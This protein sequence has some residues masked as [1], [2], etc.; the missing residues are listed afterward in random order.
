MTATLS[1]W[2]IRST[3]RR[4][5]TVNRVADLHRQQWATHTREVRGEWWALGAEA[6]VRRVG[7][8]TITATPLHRDRR[9]PQDVA[10][11]APEV[12]AAIDGLIDA[13]LLVD[14][15]PTHLRAVMFMPPLVCGVDGLEL[16]VTEVA[17]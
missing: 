17:T 15:D 13:G 9:S 1:T 11:C 10:A 3:G 7:A 6:K 12:K 2:T 14:D 8:C 5:L 4:P 16:V